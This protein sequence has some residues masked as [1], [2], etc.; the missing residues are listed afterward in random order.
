MKKEYGKIIKAND[1][2]RTSIGGSSGRSSQKN[3]M[4]RASYVCFFCIVVFFPQ[5]SYF[6]GSLLFLK[7][8]DI[9]SCL[10][11]TRFCLV[12]NLLR[13]F[14]LLAYLSPGTQTGDT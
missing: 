3:V 2:G 5:I 1:F 9:R 13:F 6:V 12:R 11:S 8:Y 4:T 7:P 10:T 14:S